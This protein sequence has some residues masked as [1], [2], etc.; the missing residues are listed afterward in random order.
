MTT[1]DRE[2]AADYP[3]APGPVQESS[4]RLRV[5]FGGEVIAETTN[6]LRIVEQNKPPV[7]YFPIED[8]R[9]EFLV[10]EET[11]ST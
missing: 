9:Q 1:A 5:E 7:Y 3:P 11:T 2:S 8:V 10:P 6:P 4:R